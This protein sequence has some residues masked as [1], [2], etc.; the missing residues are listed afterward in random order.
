MLWVKANLPAV[1]V[2]IKGRSRVVSAPPKTMVIP[3]MPPRAI[4]RPSAAYPPVHPAKGAQLEPLLLPPMASNRAYHDRRL[5]RDATSPFIPPH[6]PQN[7]NHSFPVH[8]T[9]PDPEGV[10]LGFIPPAEPQRDPAL[11]AYKYPNP[12]RAQFHRYPSLQSIIDKQCPKPLDFPI[13][14]ESE[15]TS[16]S[17]SEPRMPRTDTADKPTNHTPANDT[18]FA[19]P[20]YPISEVAEKN[21]H[22]D[23]PTLSDTMNRCPGPADRGCPAPSRLPKAAGC[24]AKLTSVSKA[25]TA[26]SGAVSQPEPSLPSSPISSPA[27]DRRASSRK[28]SLLT[29]YRMAKAWL[30]TSMVR[31]FKKSFP[32]NTE[33]L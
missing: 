24:S 9:P 17:E 22:L 29:R 15:P 8:V 10:L 23:A 1:Y 7:R 2:D 28:G 32:W 14:E 5:E 20:I 33:A 3:K 4:N 30:Q 6:L 12:V 27:V 11:M 13:S 25:A 26:A 21:G 18:L 31:K 16:R 19:A